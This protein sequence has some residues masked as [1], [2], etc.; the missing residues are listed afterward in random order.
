M[1]TSADDG[2]GRPEPPGPGPGVTIDVQAVNN[3]THSAIAV[4]V[5]RRRRTA[6]TVAVPRH[7]TPVSRVRRRR[8]RAARRRR[9]GGS[10]CTSS[11]ATVAYG[12]VYIGGD[13]GGVFAFD[14]F[15]GAPLSHFLTGGFVQ[16]SPTVA[17]GLVFVGS[18]DGNVYALG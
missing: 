14:A 18:G 6:G 16:A 11:S 9:I 2:R 8:H 17:N 10:A 15:S 5:A 12:N 3:A 7:G 1:R 4:F 13:E